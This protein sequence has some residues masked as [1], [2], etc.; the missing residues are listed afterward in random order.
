M[1]PVEQIQADFSLKESLEDSKF[2]HKYQWIIL[3]NYLPLHLDFINIVYIL[4][5]SVFQC[6]EV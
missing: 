2:V 5:L 6:T 4:T 3:T 1:N